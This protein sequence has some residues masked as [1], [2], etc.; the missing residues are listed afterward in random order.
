[1]ATAWRSAIRR[2]R[3]YLLCFLLAYSATACRSK[4]I[5]TTEDRQL[6]QF[7]GLRIAQT[8]AD[9]LHIYI[10]SPSLSAPAAPDRVPRQGRVP[11][12]RAGDTL[13]IIR[14][15]SAATTISDSTKTSE[16]A[17]SHQAV[18]HPKQNSVPTSCHWLLWP[19]LGLAVFVFLTI[20]SD[21]RR[22]SDPTQS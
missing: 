14:A 3:L 11:A 18:T 21:I 16:T 13:H 5:D 10:T 8:M 7:R 15:A 2:T 4:V 9:S 19:A 17:A 22:R 6:E 12:L 1:M 20:A